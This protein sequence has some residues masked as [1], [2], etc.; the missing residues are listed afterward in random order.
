MIE[1]NFKRPQ[2][3]DKE[4]IS[5]YFNH[6]TSRSCERTFV[7]VYLWAK[8]YGVEFAVV[9]NAL[10]FKSEREGGISYAYPAGEPEDVKNA[11]EVL[12]EYSRERGV[13][14][15]L[16]NVTPDNFAQLAE[17]YPDRFQ[18]EYSEADADYVY[19]SEKLATL[20]GKKL[21]GKRNHINKFKNMYGDRWSYEPIT[22]DNVEDCFQ[23]A[24]K[25]RNQNG[26]EDD[27]DKNSEMCVTLNSLRLFEE[28]ELTG[29][30]LR[31]DGNIIAF[32]IGE[33]VCSDTFVVHIEKAFADIQGAYPMINQQFVEHEC[34]D[35]K[36]VNREE[37]TGSEGLRKAKL[38]Y[39]PVF[40]VE[41]GFVTEKDR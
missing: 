41:K 39:R 1:I 6:H 38:S 2:L 26:C 32:T 34:K 25:W 7:N 14:F 12:M 15:S 8:H 24:L 18:I 5:H 9:E 4:L 30:L 40:M 19:E 31:V 17:W 21:H 28:L 36:Y 27:P 10:V 20:S 33:P 16:Y 35:Y 3:E 11:L 22:R 37:D 23:M 13:L 29:G